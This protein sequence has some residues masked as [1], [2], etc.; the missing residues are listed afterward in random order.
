MGPI[1]Q[2]SAPPPSPDVMRQQLPPMSQF[3]GA[4]SQMLSGQPA[5]PDPKQFAMSELNEIKGRLM[6]VVK[7]LSQ[8]N[9]ELMPIIQKMAEAGSALEN[10]LTAQVSPVGGAEAPP[11]SEVP[12]DMPLGQ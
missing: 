2:S 10:E 11:Q 1:P 7:V 9:P 8:T 4:G 6:N 3:G 12:S 5:Q